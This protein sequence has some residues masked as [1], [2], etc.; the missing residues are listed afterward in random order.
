VVYCVTRVLK[1]PGPAI[2]AESTKGGWCALTPELMLWCPESTTPALYPICTFRAEWYQPPL[3]DD[4]GDPPIARRIDLEPRV[5][6]HSSDLYFEGVYLIPGKST[7][8]KTYFGRAAR[9]NEN[10][11]LFLQPITNPSH[12]LYIGTKTINAA[13]IFSGLLWEGSTTVVYT[14]VWRNPVV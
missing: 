8:K 9:V 10:G 14:V 7:H 2:Q 12:W 3:G 13:F 4:V 11:R 5:L 1:S 6:V